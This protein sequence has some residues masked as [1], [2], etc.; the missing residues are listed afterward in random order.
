ML[1]KS[2]HYVVLGFPKCGQHTILEALKK[3]DISRGS[4]EIAWQK[5]AVEMYEGHSKGAIPIFIKRNIYDFL[6]SGY[7]YW[8]YAGVIPFKDFLEIQGNDEAKFGELNPIKRADFTKWITP[9]D[10]HNP[11]VFNVDDFTLH[12]FKT[13]RIKKSLSSEDY[14]LIDKKWRDYCIG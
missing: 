12:E 11:I 14:T 2:K 8:G 5:N 4:Y 6:L 1:D 9:F 13:D 10:K 3:E 7:N